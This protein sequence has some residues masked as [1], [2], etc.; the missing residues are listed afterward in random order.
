M[1]KHLERSINRLTRDLI[2]LSSIVEESVAKSVDALYKGD[3]AIAKNVIEKDTEIDAK[4]IE[5]EEECLKIIALNQPVA[6]D[7][8]RL[9]VILK[10]N[11]DLERIG[12]LAKN[13]SRHAIKILNNSSIVTEIDIKEISSRVLNMVK[14]SI[15][16]FVNIESETAVSVLKKD[17]EVDDL[18]KKL[19]NKLAEKLKSDPQNSLI[20]L[21]HIHIIRHLERIADHATNIAE[22]I[23][24]LIDGNIVRHPHLKSS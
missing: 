1:S 13:I 21:Q 7:L 4:E 18:N 12:D 2:M 24:Y 16:S 8:R 19:T 14:M 17:D 6:I 22:D 9:V 23:L 3:P 10:I 15:D 20:Y 11:N 5:I